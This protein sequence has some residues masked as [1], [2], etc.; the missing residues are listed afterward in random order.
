MR[1]LGEPLARRIRSTAAAALLA[2]LATIGCGPRC[3]TADDGG[4]PN[5]VLVTLDT[6]RA[7]RIGAFG[8]DG[9][10]TPALDRLA[11]EGAAFLQA[12]T[13]SHITIPSHV[14]IMSSLPVATHGA[15]NNGRPAQPVT[16]LLPDVLRAAGYQTAAFV[17]ARHLGRGGPLGAVLGKSFDVY[18]A[19]AD[20]DAPLPG[21]ETTARFAHWLRK[22]CHAPFF[23]WVHYWDP[24]TPYTPAPPFAPSTADGANGG[25]P[26]VKAQLGW[27]LLDLEEFRPTLARH[28]PAVRALKHALGVRGADVERFV[29]DPHALPDGT[30]P[31]TRA[32]VD[33]LRK[34]VRADLPLHPTLGAWVGEIDDTADAHARYAGEVS[35][36]DREVG[37]LVDALAAL[38]LG[39]DTIVVVVADHGE[40]L[41]EHGIF[42]DHEGLYEPTVH[43]PLIVWAPGRVAPGRHRMLASTLDVAPTILTLAGV[44]VPGEMDGANLLSPS[45]EPRDVVTESLDRHQAML[46]RGRWK[47]IRTAQDAY[48]SD[49]FAP[50]RGTIELY[51]LTADPSETMNVAGAH[52]AL[53]GELTAALDAWERDALRVVPPPVPVDE[54]RALG[55]LP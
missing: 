41:G 48:Y 13:A 16:P 35:Y 4:P 54:L 19:T 33:R 3:R 43:V 18:R 44:P 2:L 51:D 46:R 15:V 47:L 34:T 1:A 49:G 28:A 26:V 14:S 31:E 32:A 50:R 38:G 23:A 25:A 6:T 7:D 42:F 29:L 20:W 21:E 39:G 37:A 30:A 40:S 24:H 12:Y 11:G 45:P 5:V 22:A 17:S 8:G 9:A 53:V 27:P 10:V 36:A 52:P 55:Y